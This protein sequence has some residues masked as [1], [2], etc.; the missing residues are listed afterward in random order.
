MR[1]S[2]EIVR[3]I[4]SPN[5]GSSR[6]R[7]CDWKLT[8]Y[9]GNSANPYFGQD[10][11]TQVRKSANCRLDGL[12]KALFSLPAAEWMAV[13]LKSPKFRLAPHRGQVRFVESFN[14]KL[15]HECLNREWFR[16]LREA[17]VLI[18]QWREFYNHRRPHSSLGNRTPVQARQEALRM[19]PR[20]T[21]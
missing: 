13:T 9:C 3:S 8:K 1:R 5:S 21:A 6:S 7:V 2:Q 11:I 18:E 14:G 15:R 10:G 4:L 16:D 20:L 12:S 17:P 19:E